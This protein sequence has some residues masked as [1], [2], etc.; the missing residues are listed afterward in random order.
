MRPINSKE[1]EDI[2]LLSK[3]KEQEMDLGIFIPNTGCNPRHRFSHR[4]YE[5]PSCIFLILIPFKGL[6]KCS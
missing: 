1:I 4:L 2:F 6:G 5:H 3:H